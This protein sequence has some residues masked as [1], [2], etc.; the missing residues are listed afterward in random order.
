M[1]IAMELMFQRLPRT[2]RFALPPRVLVLNVAARTGAWRSMDRQARDRATIV[3]HFAFGATTGT[4]FSA[5]AARAP[6]SPPLV[7]LLYGIAVYLVSYAG[8]IPAMRLYPS[9]KDDT[10]HR[11]LLMVAAHLVWGGTLG[12]VEAQA[13]HLRAKA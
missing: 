3:A 7:G 4:V 8:W 10:P 12:V 1:T 5:I 13:R 11:A 2:Q 6:L 9:P